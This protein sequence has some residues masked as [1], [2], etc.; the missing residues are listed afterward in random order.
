[1]ATESSSARRG[2]PTNVDNLAVMPFA[3]TDNGSSALGKHASPVDDEGPPPGVDGAAY[4]RAMFE[5]YK[6]ADD[7]QHRK[8]AAL[9]KKT[10]VLTQQIQVTNYIAFLGNTQ[11][12]DLP[13]LSDAH[14]GVEDARRESGIATAK[15]DLHIYPH[16]KSVVLAPFMTPLESEEE[17]MAAVVERLLKLPRIKATD[18]E[19]PVVQPHMRE[20][21]TICSDELTKRTGAA[22]CIPVSAAD[23]RLDAEEIP[24]MV[25]VDPKVL[26]QG[27][28]MGM[29]AL[30][31]AL[32]EVCIPLQR[33][34]AGRDSLYREALAQLIHRSVW[35][36]KHC[37]YV[38]PHT[39]GIITCGETIL[40]VQCFHYKKD[41]ILLPIYVTDPMMLHPTSATD[42]P[43]GLRYLLR[44]MHAV[45]TG[46]GE[47]FP[48]L[49]PSVPVALSSIDHHT[50][51]RWLGCGKFS[52]VM[53][54]E[55]GGRTFALKCAIDGLHEGI[56][57]EAAIL[58]AFHDYTPEELASFPA[59]NDVVPRFECKFEGVIQNVFLK[60]CMVFGPVG[61]SLD[62]AATKLEEI[63]WA[64]IKGGATGCEA[65]PFEENV[66]YFHAASSIHSATEAEV[67]SFYTYKQLL[68]RKQELALK[69]WNAG[70]VA[71][72]GAYRLGINHRDVHC[73]NM[74]LDTMECTATAILAAPCLLMDWG[75]A[76]TSAASQAGRTNSESKYVQLPDEA[77]SVC[78]ML[79]TKKLVEELEN[80]RCSL[81]L[82]VLAILFG[83][84]GHAPYASALKDHDNALRDDIAA[85]LARLR[86]QSSW[87]IRF[88]SDS[89]FSSVY[90]CEPWLTFGK[91]VTVLQ[92]EAAT[93]YEDAL[94]EADR[95]RMALGL[96]AM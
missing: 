14:C 68:T 48:P 46:S 82:V 84:K 16:D 89:L 6:L 65:I 58:Q 27:K 66:D 44:W 62:V 49:L 64:S 74:L 36:F 69:V 47:F 42:R 95:E 57:R 43:E 75:C 5:S 18:A 19:V 55:K 7:L 26:D 29:S 21:H 10:D 80:D 90:Q 87:L 93:A 3:A 8:L 78:S 67:C 30:A 28:L 35:R 81:C 54:V 12:S 20:L 88:T 9:E 4:W 13:C 1:M 37:L 38:V 2:S 91:Y 63:E 53:E 17:I 11:G 72:E 76:T 60:E 45:A 86:A 41:G 34:H 51:V 31:H 59:F 77:R 61:I 92:D 71:L 96:V 32:Y 50:P 85:G 24:D 79:S 94:E 83:H 70:W 52:F 56:P 22:A 40:F 23:A 73:R 39:Y 15:Q 33:A 25:F